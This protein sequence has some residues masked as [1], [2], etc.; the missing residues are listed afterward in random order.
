MLYELLVTRSLWGQGEIPDAGQLV[1]I[2]PCWL[3]H[4]DCS[5]YLSVL[6]PST[7]PG[8]LTPSPRGPVTTE[9]VPHRAGA[10]KHL[11]QLY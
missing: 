7:G 11:V 1:Y 6:M 10:L 3:V 9:S 2:V 4:G 5:G 8:T